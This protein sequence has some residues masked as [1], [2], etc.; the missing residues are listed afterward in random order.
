MVYLQLKNHYI[1]YAWHPLEP[2]PTRRFPSFTVASVTSVASIA[3][4]HTAIHPLSSSRITTTTINGR[5][6][7]I[8]RVL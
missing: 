4:P 2:Y 6:L 1:C 5:S 7:F 8:A 3:V